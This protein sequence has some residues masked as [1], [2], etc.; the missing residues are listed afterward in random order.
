MSK[1][2]SFFFFFGLTTKYKEKVDWKEQLAWIDD[3]S[4]RSNQHWFNNY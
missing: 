1:V 2:C 3:S 4:M